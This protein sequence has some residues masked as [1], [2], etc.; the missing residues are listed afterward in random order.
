MRRTAVVAVA[1][2]VVLAA[3]GEDQP[4]TAKDAPVAPGG[5]VEGQLTISQW[6]LYI[7]PGK[8]GTIN[9]FEGARGVDVE[10]HRGHQRQQRVLR[11]AASDAGPA[12]TRAG[13]A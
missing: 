2:A 3:C 11:Q 6:P 5:P 1:F 7:D 8:N 4:N 10:L 12:A 13:A 9:E